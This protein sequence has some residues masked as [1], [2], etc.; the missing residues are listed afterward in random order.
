MKAKFTKVK[1]TLSQ[2]KAKNEQVPEEL[3]FEKIK[4]LPQ[5][6]Q[7]AVRT[8]FEAACRKS[9][10]RMKYGKEWLLEC[11]L[12]RMRSPKLYEHLRRQEILTLPGRTCLNKAAQH[13]KSGFGFNPNVFTALKEKVKELDG[14]NRHGVVVF[15]EIKL[16]EHIDVKPSGTYLLPLS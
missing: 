16:S 7:A 12:M 13:F 11:I 3:V 5:K 1:M 10:K 4:G 9:K 15:D 2:M 14:F 8:C 6:Q